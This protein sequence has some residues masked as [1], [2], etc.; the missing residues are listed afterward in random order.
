MLDSNSLLC[1][2]P[3]YVPVLEV[4]N[5]RLSVNNITAEELAN[6]LVR[7]QFRSVLRQ[8]WETCKSPKCQP[9]SALLLT[10][11]PALTLLRDFRLPVVI[12]LTLHYTSLTPLLTCPFCGLMS[13]LT[14]PPLP[15]VLGCRIWFHQASLQHRLQ[16]I[17]NI[18]S[19][20]IPNIVDHSLT[21][22]SRLLNWNMQIDPS[23]SSIPLP[24]FPMRTRTSLPINQASTTHSAPR[25][26][27]PT[28][29][30]ASPSH[31]VGGTSA[32]GRKASR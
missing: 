17:Y 11:S 1:R 4:L 10:L 31:N 25:H 24:K 9:P 14:H 16:S 20:N 18:A 13:L 5:F 8:G 26:S 22:P 19:D 21:N 28:A 2:G 7:Y 30:S 27:P 23:Y 29:S 12:P 3:A 6:G 15:C 32:G